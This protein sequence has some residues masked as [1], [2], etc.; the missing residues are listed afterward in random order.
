MEQIKQHPRLEP[1]KQV[2]TE[3]LSKPTP[4]EP[5]LVPQTQMTVPSVQPRK[6]QGRA[7]IR[8]KIIGPKS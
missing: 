1:E 2:N 5:K 7:G 4:V 8:R 3:A 6:G